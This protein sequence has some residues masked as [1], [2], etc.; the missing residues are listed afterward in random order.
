MTVASP[1]L[2]GPL[3]Y[4]LPRPECDYKVR[5]WTGKCTGTPAGCGYYLDTVW[6]YFAAIC[7]PYPPEAK[8]VV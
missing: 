8:P 3:F 5:A 2:S 7:D 1:H 4:R 6:L